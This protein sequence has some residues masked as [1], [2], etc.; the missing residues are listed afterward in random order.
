MK[1]FA[2]RHIGPDEAAQRHM[3]ASLGYASLDELIRAALPEDATPAQLTLPGPLTE[4]ESLAELR[5]MADRNQVLTSM[6]GLGYYDTITPAVIRRNVLE[7][8]AWY[9]AYTPYQPEISQGRLEAL[10]NFQTMVADLTALPWAGA[11][12][13][14]EATAAV[15]A[16]TL[17]RRAARRGHVFLADADCLPQTLAVLRTRAEPLGIHLVVEPVTAEVIEAQDDLFGVLLQFPGASGVVQDLGP[18]IEA[19]HARGALAAVAADLL[20][21]TLLTPP[22]ELGADI[23]VGSSQRFGVPLFYGGPH[24]GYIAV[25]EPLKRQ[26]PGRLVGVSVD[27]DGRPAYRLALQAREQHIRREKA[28]SNICTAQALL[29]VMAGLYAAYH[30]PDGIRRIA[31]RV[32]ALTATLAHGLEKLGLEIEHGAFFDTLS[33]RTAHDTC[34]RVMEVALSRGINLRRVAGECV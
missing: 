20:A 24:A 33:V 6:I 23:A 32:H 3:L 13:L 2:A 26:L 11:S 12:L 16:M 30:G 19:A 29:A 1:D 27:A 18:L 7:N 15:E 14:D 5:R 28:T 22:G 10:L 17:A 21:L 4:T 31:T 9:T 34:D 25:S 8:P